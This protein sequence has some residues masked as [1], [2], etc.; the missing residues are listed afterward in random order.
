MRFG[1]VIHASALVVAPLPAVAAAQITDDEPPT[2]PI[3]PALAATAFAWH[4]GGRR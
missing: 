1:T 2:D 3:P 4:P